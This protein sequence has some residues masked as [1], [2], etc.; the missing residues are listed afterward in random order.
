VLLGFAPFVLLRAAMVLLGPQSSFVAASRQ[1]WMPLTLLNQL[2]M[3]V[4]PLLIAR[5]RN[6]HLVRLPRPR[7]VLVEALFAVLVVPVAFATLAVGPLLLARLLGGTEPPPVPWGPLAGSFNRAQWV[8]FILLAVALAPVAEETFYRGFLYNALRQRFHPI[9]A[10]LMQAA[11]FGYA[12][13]F[14]LANSAAIG[15]LALV[16]ALVYEWRKTLLTPILLHS[17][18]NT[19]GMLFLASNLAADAAAPR[20]GVFGEARQGGCLVTEVSP[21]S[22]A[23]AAGLQA[24]DVITSVNGERVADI[25]TLALVIRKHQLGDTVSIEFLR[26]GKAHRADVVLVRLKQ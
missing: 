24:G 12:H 17:A 10:A 22:A 2:W 8:V 18:V 11:V 13:P 19:V 6:T 3:L 26:G 5:T 23:D 7:A 20:L 4:V 15:M 21:G 16:L 14:G 1:F 9:L 25:P